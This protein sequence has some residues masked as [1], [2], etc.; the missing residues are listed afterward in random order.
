MYV[1][2]FQDAGNQ[3]LT[4]NCPAQNHIG[5][6]YKFLQ[7]KHAYA[8][9]AINIVTIP[10]PDAGITASDIIKTFDE[11]PH[12]Y[13]WK[14]GQNSTILSLCAKHLKLVKMIFLD[15][16]CIYLDWIKTSMVCLKCTWNTTGMGRYYSFKNVI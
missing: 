1:E 5:S 6:E 12:E 9:H 4:K 8:F 16:G 14:R 13:Q 11:K 7:L 10:Q 2:Y 15:E 3:H